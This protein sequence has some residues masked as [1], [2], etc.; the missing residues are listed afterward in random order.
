M[1]IRAHKNE[2]VKS[3]CIYDH[4]YVEKNDLKLDKKAFTTL[5]PIAYLA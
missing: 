5:L 3:E 4:F 1:K 2:G